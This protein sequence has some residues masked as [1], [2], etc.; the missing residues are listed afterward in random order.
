MNR[1]HIR[2]ITYNNLPTKC[3]K[4]SPSRFYLLLCTH[5]DQ[6]A[7]SHASAVSELVV[8]SGF[9]NTHADQAA[10]RHASA[11]SELVVVLGF[12]NTGEF[13]DLVEG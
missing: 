2:Y 6:A 1:C 11:V 5:A 8:V 9:T 4:D 10:C 13:V 7:C 3:F 12:T